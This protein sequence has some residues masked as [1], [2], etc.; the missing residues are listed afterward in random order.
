MLFFDAIKQLKSRQ[1]SIHCT[2]IIIISL[3]KIYALTPLP[4]V[5]NVFVPSVSY[6]CVDICQMNACICARKICVRV[7]VLLSNEF[8]LLSKR[9]FFKFWCKFLIFTLN[10]VIPNGK[11]TM[12]PKFYISEL[13]Y[14]NSY[15]S[16]ASAHMHSH[17]HTSIKST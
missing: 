1:A 16:L 4:S 11:N 5:C 15:V 3:Y 17:K 10:V 7:F 14:T 6:A 9:I 12:E 2:H 13:Q 8:F